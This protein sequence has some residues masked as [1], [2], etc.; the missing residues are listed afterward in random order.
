MGG[1]PPTTQS[2]DSVMPCF[3]GGEYCW[4]GVFNII[5]KKWYLIELA[6]PAHA[7]SMTVHCS[8]VLYA[9]GVVASRPVVYYLRND[10]WC[11]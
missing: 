6:D 5:F 8:R 3:V 7:T 4:W 1:N 11:R 9:A 10:R 2:V